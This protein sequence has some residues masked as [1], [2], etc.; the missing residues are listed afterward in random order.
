MD[1]KRLRLVAPVHIAETRE[2]AR[3]N[4]KHGIE[5][6]ARYYDFVAPNPF[7]I[8]GRDIVDVLIDSKR[9]VI[10]DPDDAIAMIDRLKQKQ[11]DF[12][13]FLQQHVDWADWTHTKRSY[14]LYAQY[15]MPHVN[16]ANINRIASW[17]SLER[18]A[19]AYKVKRQEAA[20]KSFD[21]H[22]A[23]KAKNQGDRSK[24]PNEMD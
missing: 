18:N 12:G 21:D 9:A 19:E 10:G 15:V 16:Q 4:V 6:W 1:R 23:A 22:E 17:D 11:G 2:K 13:V 8:A 3:E 20:Q 7:N 14:E 24:R 5:K